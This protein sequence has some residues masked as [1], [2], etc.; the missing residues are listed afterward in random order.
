M[1]SSTIHN[2]IRRFQESGKISGMKGDRWASHA[3]LKNK[4]D[5]VVEIWTKAP[6]KWT[7]AKCKTVLWSDKL[8]CL[9]FF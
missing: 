8:K 3:V 5:S 6:L 1:S 4:H 7:E 9:F 2:I